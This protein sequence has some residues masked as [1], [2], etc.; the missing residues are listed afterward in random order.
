M[1]GMRSKLFFKS[2]KRL[3]VPSFV[4]RAGA[5]LIYR[6]IL[7]WYSS[8]NFRIAY[9]DRDSDPAY[10]P[11]DQPAIYILWHEYIPLPIAM[12]QGC[13]I[14]ILVSQHQDAELLGN[15]ASFARFNVV[16]GSSNRGGT[17]ALKNLVSGCTARNI[18]I[19][20]DGPRGPR[21]KVAQGCIYLASK[22]QLPIIAVGIGYDRPWRIRRAWDQFAIPRLGS[23]GRLVLSPEL[24]VPPDLDRNE[25]EA[26][27]ARVEQVLLQ[28][29]DL[30]ENWAAGKLR[31]DPSHVFTSQPSKPTV[32]QQRNSFCG[33]LDQGPSTSPLPKY[34]NAS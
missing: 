30:A 29:S 13:N 19:T 4:W 14:T 3:R 21:R 12:R 20:P 24:H 9:Y 23:R 7:A 16:R 6:I 10:R 33:D 28:M 15:L 5:F 27:R 17:A 26:H 2:F 32:R 34:R 31:I 8:L 11:T 22:L 25:I 18:S 1:V